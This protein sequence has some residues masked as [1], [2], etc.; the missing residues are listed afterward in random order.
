MNAEPNP[1][2]INNQLNNNI[3]SSTVTLTGLLRQLKNQS[4]ADGTSSSKSSRTANDKLQR[5][6][7]LYHKLESGELSAD[8]FRAQVTESLKVTPQFEK[9]LND[10]HRSYK[11]LVNTLDIG[12]KPGSTELYDAKKA[13]TVISSTALT[14]VNPPS[15]KKIDVEDLN[16]KIT[17]YAQ[18]FSS[19]SDF[20]NYLSEK[21]VPINGELEKHIREHEETKS[22]PF[23][24][25]SKCVLSAISEEE[26]TSSFIGSPN[27]KNPNSY[28]FVN[29]QNFG[30][31]DAATK[32]K[33]KEENLKKELDKLGNGVY[34]THKRK[35]EPKV[36]NN[37]ELTSW[38]P[39]W[40][41][42]L[43]KSKT[44]SHLQHHD[45]F[46]WRSGEEEAPVVRKANIVQK[47][48][49]NSGDII[50]WQG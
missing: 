5:F 15:A 40:S 24:K 25:I 26:K 8:R 22:V 14:T 35:M 11:D 43:K 16:N 18:G 2:K 31:G 29:K 30:K 38:D 47:A 41:N 21:K 36:V 42:D 34:L 4:Y 1:G 39:D 49:L 32:E 46:S 13:P 17:A 45:I 7:D 3:S 6:K 33:M 19:R 27:K 23:H 48:A 20:L 12:K 10:P 37:G 50:K 9:A 28:R 44:M